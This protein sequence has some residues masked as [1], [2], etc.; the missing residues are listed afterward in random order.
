[1]NLVHVTELS[2][3]NSEQLSG[4]QKQRVALA[5]AL[6]NEPEIILLDEPMSALDVQLRKYLQ[7]ELRNIQKKINTTFILVSHDQEE[8][9]VVSDRIGV[10]N[11]GKMIQ[12]DSPY[13]L[14]NK[15]INKFVASF[16]GLNNIFDGKKIE[17]KIETPVGLLDVLP[18]PEWEEGS[19]SIRPEKIQIC[20][21][22]LNENN[23]IRGNIQNIIFKGSFFE[24]FVKPEKTTKD[25]FLIRVRSFLSVRFNNNENIGLFFPPKEL[26]SLN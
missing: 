25:N 17:N 11:E 3:R 10:M 20:E 5:R 2:D 21:S 6:V 13:N 24:L 9:M 14:Y 26:V 18:E 12:I 23:K 22:S 1:M 7:E 19:L 4:G 16:M 8:A 15:P